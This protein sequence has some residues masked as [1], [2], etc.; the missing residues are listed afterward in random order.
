MFDLGQFYKLIYFGGRQ[1]LYFQQVAIK[2]S[3]ILLVR[4]FYGVRL[5]LHLLFSEI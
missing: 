2:C 5:G 3:L 1:Y 4:N